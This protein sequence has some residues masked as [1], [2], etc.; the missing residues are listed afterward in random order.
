MSTECVSTKQKHKLKFNN[1]IDISNKGVECKTE[2][3]A[4]SIFQ[5]KLI[6]ILA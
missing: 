4:K 5:I 6:E 3:I 1:E 2:I